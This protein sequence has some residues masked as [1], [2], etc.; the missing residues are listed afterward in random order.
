MDYSLP[1]RL[2]NDLLAEI[3]RSI[4]RSKLDTAEKAARR[5]EDDLKTSANNTNCPA[6]EM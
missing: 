2:M 1:N 5:M 6:A 3:D 4:V